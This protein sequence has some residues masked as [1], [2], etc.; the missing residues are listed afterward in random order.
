MAA[1]DLGI[2]SG[3]YGL[4][5]DFTVSITREQFT[6]LMM[7][8]IAAQ[9]QTTVLDL[10]A[11]QGL[12][13]AEDEKP[14]PGEGENIGTAEP[15]QLPS[16]FQDTNSLHTV[17]AASM[18]LAQG[19]GGLFR[20][21]DSIKRCEAAALLFRCM[22]LLG[23]GEANSRPQVFV[24]AYEIPRWSVEAVKFCS[25]RTREDGSAIMSGFGGL[26]SPF[27]A[28]TIEQAIVTLMRCRDSLSSDAVF[29]GWRECEGYDS[30]TL[31]LTFGGDC[32]FGSGI[33]FSYAGSFGEMFSKV[34]PDYFFGG[35]EEFF[36][37]DLTMV[38][39]EGTLTTATSHATKTFCFKG[40]PEYAKALEAGSIDVVTVANNHSM[41]YLKRGFDDTIANLSPYV[42]ISG[43]ERR[44]IVTVKGVNI[45]FASNVGWVFDASQKAFIDSSVADLKARG[46]DIIVFSYHWGIERAY[47]SNS[48]QQSIARYCIDAG[49]DLVI[50]HHPHVV[51]E[52][53]TY[54]GKQIAYSL[55]NLVF[56]GN[57]NPSD[58]NCLIFRQSFAVDLNTREVSD[59]G[60][61]AVPYKISSVDY[62]ND[63]RPTKR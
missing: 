18:G 4:G 10:A 9:K 46:A 36:T 11:G 2:V 39:F 29:P 8:F 33:G 58:K 30:V 6:H 32:T 21:N 22:T 37:D 13:A 52:T 7:E 20:P 23:K 49:A 63:Y 57:H 14:V 28:Y 44:P 61:A 26:F 42:E 53:E 27:G 40:R 59:A 19:S 55:G 15:T 48:T 51:Q 50:G 16:P 5:T 47:R 62:R 60:F 54:K 24:D 38:N 31:A 45:G 12:V 1:Y 41:D 43:Y 25:G 35:I 3:D 56:G 34:T 17:L